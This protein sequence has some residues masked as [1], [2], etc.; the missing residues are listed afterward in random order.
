MLYRPKKILN[1][2]LIKNNAVLNAAKQYFND[3]RH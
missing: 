3:A 2:H 1:L